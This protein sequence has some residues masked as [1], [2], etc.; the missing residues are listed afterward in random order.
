MT[1]NAL[2]LLPRLSADRRFV[3]A[4][5]FKTCAVVRRVFEMLVIE[6]LLVAARRRRS[7]PTARIPV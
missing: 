1:D 3:R 6:N 5:K 7:F 2:S 4:R